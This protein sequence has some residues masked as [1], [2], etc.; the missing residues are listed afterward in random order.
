MAVE[1]L[2]ERMLLSAAPQVIKDIFPESGNVQRLDRRTTPDKNLF[3]RQNHFQ[4]EIVVFRGTRRDDNWTQD[5]G[6]S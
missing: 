4:P 5:T 2:E 1:S 6:E 3:D